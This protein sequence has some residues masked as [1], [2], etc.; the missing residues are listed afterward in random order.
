MLAE[1]EGVVLEI[2]AGHGVNLGAI[3]RRTSWIG[4]E[5]ST[6]RRNELVRRARAHG[7]AATVLNAPAEHIPLP[8]ESVDAVL[9][10]RVLC[11]VSDP[12]RALAE[13]LR[14]LRPSGTFIF[15]EHVAPPRGTWSHVATRTWSPIEHRFTGCRAVRD[16]MSTIAAAGFAA[17]DYTTYTT[18]D[19]LGVRIPHVVGSAR[20]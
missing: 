16:T 19:L 9:A 4:L 8:D 7:R 1:V 13:V 2:G 11:S 5:P 12:A 6:R 10:T 15:Q 20:R 17:V 18:R 14:L 3:P